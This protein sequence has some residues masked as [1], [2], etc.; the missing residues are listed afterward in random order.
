MTSP[1]PGD[2]RLAREFAKLRSADGDRVPPFEAMWRPR[3]KRRSPWWIAAP[4]ATV[5]LLATA[6]AVILWIA[7]PRSEPAPAAPPGP[8]AAQV[9]AQVTAEVTELDPQPLDFLLDSPSL[10]E[11]PDFDSNPIGNHP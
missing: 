10:G 2:D 4:V 9:T 11:T 7:H 5:P 8:A 1:E 3:P 6:A